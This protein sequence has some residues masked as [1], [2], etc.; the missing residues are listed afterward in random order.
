TKNGKVRGKQRFLCRE[1]SYNFVENDMRIRVSEEP[2]RA[3]AIL[4]YTMGKASYNF[5][6]TMVIGLP[7]DE[8]HHSFSI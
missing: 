6:A 5:L 8:S 3:L 7:L 4:L 2:K 1:C